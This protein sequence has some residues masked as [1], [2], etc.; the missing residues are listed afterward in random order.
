MIK[1]S[2]ILLFFSCYVW[3]NNIFTAYNIKETSVFDIRKQMMQSVFPSI[4]WDKPGLYLFLEKS[5]LQLFYFDFTDK[6]EYYQYPQQKKSKW[7]EP[8]EYLKERNKI[9]SMDWVDKCHSQF[10]VDTV[11]LNQLYNLQIE[12]YPYIVGGDMKLS[13][14]YDPNELLVY[15]GFKNDSNHVHYFMFRNFLSNEKDLPPPLSLYE[16][17]ISFF[18]RFPFNMNLEGCR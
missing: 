13:S 1:Y 2:F 10:K 12:T 11:T 16:R 4:S 8:E 3:S 14:Q 6:V 17:I 15:M 5:Y 9:A 18:K 7:L